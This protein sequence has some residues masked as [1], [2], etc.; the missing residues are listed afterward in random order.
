MDYQARLQLD[1]EDRDGLLN[2]Y[3][4]GGAIIGRLKEVAVHFETNEALDVPFSLE[5]EA[6]YSRSRPVAPPAAK[7]V[8]TRRVYKLPE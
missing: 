1:L 5:Y 6:T 4:E 8:I 2:V 3:G 7:T